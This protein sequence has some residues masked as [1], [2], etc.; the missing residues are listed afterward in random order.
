M[1][2]IEPKHSLA[3]GP[4]CIPSWV[5]IDQHAPVYTV[6]SKHAQVP[7]SGA[8]PFA[9]DPSDLAADAAPRKHTQYPYVTGT[10][11]IA[12]AYNGGVLI[13]SDTL[14]SYGSTKR[15]KDVQRMIKVNDSCIVGASGEVSDFQELQ[16]LLDELSTEDYAADDGIVLTPREIHSYL[17][18]VMYNRRN[19][20][21]PFWNSLV[22]A[23]MEGDKPFVGMVSMI[24]VSY[25][26]AYICTGFANHL[27]MPLIRDAH[28]PDL[29]EQE[30]VDL[31]QGCLKVCY[32]RDK[33]SMN[34]FVMG[35]VSG[36]G[37]SFSEPFAVATEWNYK[38]MENP[39][40]FCTGAW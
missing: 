29:T 37:V 14:G 34:K 16:K 25:T 36:A 20:F 23:G 32:Y 26:G 12:V 22:V 19:K 10:S 28:R 38:L 24:G 17:C 1:N 31:V 3:I 5:N 8:E 39:T 6:H 27:A 35:R 11:V 30:A 40:A 9:T 33:A 15:Y 18:R 2:P 21:D 7:L 13:A 4:G